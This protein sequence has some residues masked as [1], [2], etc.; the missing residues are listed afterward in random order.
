MVGCQLPEAV[1]TLLRYV[2][3][4]RKRIVLR[5]ALRSPVCTR[6]VSARI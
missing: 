6:H 5:E 4:S 2:Q 1:R 3:Q